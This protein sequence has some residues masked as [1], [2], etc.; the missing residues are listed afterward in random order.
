MWNG[1]N[2]LLNQIKIT[3][4]LNRIELQTLRRQYLT[5][6]N[7]AEQEEHYVK[8]LENLINVYLRPLQVLAQ[9]HSREADLLKMPAVGALLS[10]VFQVK[11]VSQELVADLQTL[12]R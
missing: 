4:S 7:L 2:P 3:T 9:Q 6:K 5:L 12:L 10:N 1:K 11:L 8:H